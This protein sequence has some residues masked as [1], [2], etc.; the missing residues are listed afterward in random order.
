MMNNKILIKLFVPELDVSYDVF[1]PI[2]EAV[3]K[4]KLLLLKSIED[5]LKIKVS[6]KN[7]YLLNKVSNK[8][9]NNNEVIINTDIRNA[10]ELLLISKKDI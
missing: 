5:M 1:I 3:W 9:Y 6:T 8:I 10:S 7:I 4:V 2:N